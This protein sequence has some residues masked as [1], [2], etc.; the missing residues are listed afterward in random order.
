MLTRLYHTRYTEQ[1]ETAD[2]AASSRGGN[3]LPL[4]RSRRLRVL[5]DLA[6]RELRERFVGL[7]FLAECRIQ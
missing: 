6:L 4:S 7:L 3:D 5:V 2:A 1:I